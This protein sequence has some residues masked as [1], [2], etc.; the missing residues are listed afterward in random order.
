M[1]GAYGG[2]RFA[3]FSNTTIEGATEGIRIEISG[4]TT[5]TEILLD[6]MT[7]T[8]CVNRGV[9]LTQVGTPPNIVL[10]IIGVTCMGNDTGFDVGN[11][12]PEDLIQIE[13][14]EASNNDYGF[15]VSSPVV[16]NRCS[17][18]DKSREMACLRQAFGIC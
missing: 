3:R 2:E 18:P 4:V 13:G 16:V 14:C 6:T 12:F 8:N 10:T 15:K 5:N 7:I 1:I 11:G 9:Y 17:I